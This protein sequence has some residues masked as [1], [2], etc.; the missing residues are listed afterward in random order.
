MKQRLHLQQNVYDH[1]GPKGHKNGWC[2][3]FFKFGW[4]PRDVITFA[5]GWKWKWK[6]EAQI[7]LKWKVFTQGFQKRSQPISENQYISRYEQ[8][9]VEKW[10]HRWR[11]RPLKSRQISKKFGSLERG[12]FKEQK[13]LLGKSE[14]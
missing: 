5:G 7:W 2:P 4:P 12:P 14:F 3:K 1:L 8:K 9:K 10:R 11:H 13:I 6:L